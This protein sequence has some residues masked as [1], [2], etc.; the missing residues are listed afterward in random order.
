[1]FHLGVLNHNG[2]RDG[3]NYVSGTVPIKYSLQNYL[4]VKTLPN[5]VMQSSVNIGVLLLEITVLS[6]IVLE[7]NFSFH[8]NCLKYWR[9]WAM[10]IESLLTKICKH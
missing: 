5:A 4:K 2:V 1:V 3:K 9:V 6:K 7:W 10:F 8:K